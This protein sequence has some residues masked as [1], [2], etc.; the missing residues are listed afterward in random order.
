MDTWTIA[1]YTAHTANGVVVITTPN[2]GITYDTENNRFI[3]PI[4][5]QQDFEFTDGGTAMTATY[6]LVDGND[7]WKIAPTV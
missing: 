1:S 7:T 4:T 2:T 6:S 3:I 5:Y